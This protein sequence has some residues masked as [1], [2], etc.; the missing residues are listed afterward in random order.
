VY[1]SKT[2]K[3]NRV[4]DQ[5]CISR[6]DRKLRT[7]ER[8]SAHGDFLPHT[9]HYLVR[10]PLKYEECASFEIY[11]TGNWIMD[12]LKILQIPSGAQSTRSS[13]G[14]R[15]RYLSDEGEI[16]SLKKMVTNLQINTR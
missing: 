12:G 14:L 6:R 13:R 9:F 2:T 15:R 5:P 10:N 11:T 7:G 3:V 16:I 4:A 1:P 8:P